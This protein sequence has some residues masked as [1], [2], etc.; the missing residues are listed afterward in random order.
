[1]GRAVPATR[2][3]GLSVPAPVL[4]GA[5]TGGL[6]AKSAVLSAQQARA[7]QARSSVQQMQAR[8]SAFPG[9]RSAGLLS[10]LA[11]IEAQFVLRTFT[12]QQFWDW[13]AQGNASA[14]KKEQAVF[15]AQLALAAVVTAPVPPPVPTPVP[16]PVTARKEAQQ[17]Q[18]LHQY[19][20]RQEW[21][22]KLL[23]LRAPWE[24][25]KSSQLMMQKLAR[26]LPS[27]A[28]QGP[29]VAKAPMEVLVL[30]RAT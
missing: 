8:M 15:G 30:Q 1:M 17:L 2:P 5:S 16:A 19:V 22:A 23:D 29:V 7:Q 3:V 13:V 4:G 25:A 20:A 26:Q 6:F 12:P 11:D 14:T 27:D 10:A 18:I 24:T 28:T 21:Q 9:T